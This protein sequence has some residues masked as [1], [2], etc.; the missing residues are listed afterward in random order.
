M[1]KYIN[2][3]EVEV[4]ISIPVE[5]DEDGEPTRWKTHTIKPNAFLQF[6]EGRNNTS[7]IIDECIDNNL[8]QK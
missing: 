2:Q 1:T 4:D 6:N 3:T 5:Y 7:A 8:T